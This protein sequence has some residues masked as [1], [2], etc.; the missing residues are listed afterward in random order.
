MK[1]KLNFIVLL[2]AIILTFLS[3]CHKKCENKD[4]C[5]YDEK[6]DCIR[7][8]NV[9]FWTDNLD[10]TVSVTISG[11]TESI[12]SELSSEPNCNATGCANFSLCSGTYNYVASS[13]YDDWSGT[14]TITEDG[15]VKI[16]LN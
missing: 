8:G 10:A 1:R 15:C 13:H 12:V 16:C 3:G 9:T 2:S 14:V 6:G 7:K 5:N 11:T 4:A